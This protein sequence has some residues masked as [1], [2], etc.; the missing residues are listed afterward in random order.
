[1]ETHCVFLEVQSEFQ[2]FHRYTFLHYAYEVRARKT[3]RVCLSV[4]P[5]VRMIRIDNRL[6]DFGEIWRGRYAIKVSL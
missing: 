5:S 1:M 2:K 6:T 4:R 3:V